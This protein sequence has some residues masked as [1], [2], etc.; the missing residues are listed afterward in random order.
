MAEDV[1]VKVVINTGAWFKLSE[2]AILRYLALTGQ[3]CW[4]GR[5]RGMA[6]YWLIPPGPELD[7]LETA[8]TNFYDFTTEERIA[9]REW[10]SRSAF[11]ERA[12]ERSD[13]MLLQ[14][15]EELGAKAAGK[16]S[17]LK[18]VEIPD[19]VEW[20]IIQEEDGEEYVAEKHRR[21]S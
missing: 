21:W 10:Y 15:V 8:I 18:V 7:G 9:L 5:R 12:I 3:Q 19:G 14:V 16:G 11:S 2:E 17:Q 4:P 6:V 13:P 20:E 1:N